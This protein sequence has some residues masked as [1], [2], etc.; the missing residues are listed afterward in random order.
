VHSSIDEHDASDRFALFLRETKSERTAHTQSKYEYSVAT[1]GEFSKCP[2]NLGVPVLPSREIHVLPSGAMA[3][4]SRKTY[5]HALFGE[6]L[7][8]RQHRLG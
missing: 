2:I 5:R 7:R 3:G 4:E 8:Q 1:L 6:A